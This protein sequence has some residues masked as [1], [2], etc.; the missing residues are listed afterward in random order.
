M[1]LPQSKPHTRAYTLARIHTH[2]H[3]GRPAKP[4]V[5]RSEFHWE[6]IDRFY[7]ARIDWRKRNLGGQEEIWVGDQKKINKKK[8]N[9]IFCRRWDS[10]V[11]RGNEK[12]ENE[13]GD[14]KAGLRN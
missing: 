2:T 3:A 6:F 4:T 1:S 7:T 13:G 12:D 8:F 11:E 9:Q 5:L 10:E 14:Y